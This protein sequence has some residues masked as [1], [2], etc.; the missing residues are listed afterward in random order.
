MPLLACVMTP[1]ARPSRPA[2]LLWIVAGMLGAFLLAA[3]YTLLDL[4][5]VPQSV[6]AAVVGVPRAARHDRSRSG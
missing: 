1:A 2:A 4:P 3:P 5:D 6:R